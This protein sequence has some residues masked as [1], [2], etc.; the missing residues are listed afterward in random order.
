[1]AK[2]KLKPKALSRADLF[3]KNK[4]KIV[5]VKIQGFGSLYVKS[6]Q[7]KERSQFLELADEIREKGGDT[8]AVM[9]S[10]LYHAVCDKK[11]N[12]F[13]QEEDIPKIG[14]LDAGIVHAL[15]EKVVEL[16]MLGNAGTDEAKKP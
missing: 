8:Y 4:P 9:L 12:R 2:K 10:S 16:N 1:M 7:L 6:M 13:F 14:E 5:E 15:F 11:G 3:A